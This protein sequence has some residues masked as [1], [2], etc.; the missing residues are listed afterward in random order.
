[1]PTIRPETPADLEAVTGLIASAF[2]KTDADGRNDETRLV[3]GLR[4][5]GH[6][7]VSLVA[8]EG[9]G[10]VGQIM[11]SEVAIEAS[12]GP[13]PALTLAPLA[14]APGRQGEGIG[15]DLVRSGI[16]ECRRTGWRIVLVV[17]HPGYYPRFGFKRDLA[18]ALGDPFKAGDAFMA[19]ELEPGA[20]E[21]V[22]GAVRYPPPFMA[23]V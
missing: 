5:G 1:M 11:F 6:V 9:G 3:D 12:S 2:G 16:E 4:D 17:G 20:L 18:R 22:T 15:S 14:V 8:E 10:I 19:M 7:R 13:V 21:G 23:F